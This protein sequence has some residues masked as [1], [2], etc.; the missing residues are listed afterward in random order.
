MP[1]AVESDPRLAAFVQFEIYDR[2]TQ[3]PRGAISENRVS[4]HY[5]YGASREL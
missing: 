4:D 2:P 5:N 1:R 3:S